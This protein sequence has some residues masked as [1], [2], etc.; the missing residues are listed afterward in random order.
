ML[1]SAAKRHR[2]TPPHVQRAC[3]RPPNIR[4]CRG[5]G[6][7]AR[8]ALTRKAWLHG[9]CADLGLWQVTRTTTGTPWARRDN[10]G[11]RAGAG[12]VGRA[13][14]PPRTR[15]TAHGLPRLRRQ[16]RQPRPGRPRR[17]RGRRRRS[18]DGPRVPTATECRLRRV[19]GSAVGAALQVRHPPAGIVLRSPFTELA[20][21]GVHHY[22]GRYRCAR[23][24]ATGSP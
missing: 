19:L 11:N 18:L 5:E 13:T 23:C 4:S 17:R 2:P 22:P 24:C 14:E 6:G 15:G 3:R 8:P 9:P 10:G 20:D 16:P 21:A 1:H 7:Y 12:R